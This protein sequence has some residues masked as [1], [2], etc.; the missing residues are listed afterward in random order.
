MEI[1]SLTPK[2][3]KEWNDFCLA[4]DDAWFW[5]NSAWLEYTLNYKPALKP[6]SKSFMVLKNNQVIAVCPLI[7]ETY[8]DI[9]E[10]SFGSEHG[11]VP[12]FAGFLTAKEKHDTEKFVFEHIDKL[13]K[14]NNVNRAKFRFPVLNKSFIES[15]TQKFNFL[16][17]F[18]YLDNSLLT[19]VLDIRKSIA[20][21]KKGLR[22]GHDYDID[23]AGKILKAEIFNKENITEEIFNKYIQ[24]HEKAAGRITRPKIT[25]DIMYGLIKNGN[26]FLA[27]AEK[28]DKFIGFSY[29]FAF[30]N[31][32][33]YG[34]SCVDPDSENI[35]VSHFIQWKAIEWMKKKN[36]SFYQIGCQHFSNAVYNFPDKKQIDI[37]RFERG[38]G[39]F[40]VSLFAGEKFY[41]REYFLKIYQERINKFADTMEK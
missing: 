1:I 8:E 6:E 15:E 9:K 41:D 37:S 28:D 17:K 21:L 5:H 16:M 20:E 26:S 11:P 40:T 32:V 35:P 30:K 34:S 39:G 36:F 25:F 2:K 3:Y 10:F 23:R 13:A 27:G 38:F 18:G 12:A 31:N 19:Q 24:L 33:H 22:H 7:L 4:S 29:F 14:K